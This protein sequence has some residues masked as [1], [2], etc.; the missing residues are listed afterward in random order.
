MEGYDL[1]ALT[2]G[3]LPGGGLGEEELFAL[4]A[5]LLPLLAERA[6]RYTMNES[7]SVPAETAGELLTSVCFLIGL[8][9]LKSGLAALPPDADFGRLFA[10]GLQT[11]QEEIERGKRLWQAACLGAPQV[12]NIA[13]R[14]TLKGIGRF[15]KRYD[16]R[17]FAHRIPC[18]I[19]Y[20][21][22]R[23]VPDT[24][25]G[26]SYVNEYLRRVI[27]ENALVRAFAQEPVT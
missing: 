8:A 9:L 2:N 11:A 26:V 21:L 6:A 5:K 4:Q 22:C 7:S 15:W 13:Y 12:Q 17:F 20:P 24:L 23:A 14:D 10:L 1:T 25:F 27:W 18:D 3:A 16:H 19:D